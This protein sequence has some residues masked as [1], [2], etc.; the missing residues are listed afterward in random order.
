MAMADDA[1]RHRRHRPGRSGWRWQVEQSAPRC[2]AWRQQSRVQTLAAAEADIAAAGAASVAFNPRSPGAAR[3]VDV[4]AVLQSL[5]S[6]VELW[7]TPRQAGSR[8]KC[9]FSRGLIHLQT[10]DAALLSGQPRQCNGT[11]TSASISRARKLDWAR[12]AHSS[13][14]TTPPSP[15]PQMGFHKAA[16][17]QPRTKGR[18][19]LAASASP[20]RTK[21]THVAAVSA[22]PSITG[23]RSHRNNAAPRTG[24]RKVCE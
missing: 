6:K 1:R 24:E 20:R 23:E 12:S 18:H 21:T 10:D 7:F 8:V 22:R 4:R 17:L 3:P 11:G 14:R 19:A 13:P 5:V 15:S 9:V 16:T 2:G